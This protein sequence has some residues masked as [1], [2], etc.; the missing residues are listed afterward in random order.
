M[1]CNKP[2]TISRIAKSEVLPWNWAT[3]ILYLY[4]NAFLMAQTPDGGENCEG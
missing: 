1:E 3:F 2:Y 4:R